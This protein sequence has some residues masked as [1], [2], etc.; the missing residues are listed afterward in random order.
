MEKER[1]IGFYWASI[2]KRNGDVEWSIYFYDS[3]DWYHNGRW[4]PECDFVEIDEERLV[5]KQKE[6]AV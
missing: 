1:E 5:R 2:K 4:Y 6:A 3:N